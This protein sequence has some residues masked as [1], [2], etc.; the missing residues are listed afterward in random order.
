[1]NSVS[2]HRGYVIN[3]DPQFSHYVIK[4]DGKGTVADSLTGYFQKADLARLAIDRYLDE[5][6]KK[7]SPLLESI[8][9][10]TPDYKKKEKTV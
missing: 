4:L 1:M 9:S 8:R 2:E 5:E 6:K 7:V 3:R 10:E